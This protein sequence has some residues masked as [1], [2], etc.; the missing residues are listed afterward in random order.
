VLLD[1]RSVTWSCTG[2]VV[3]C[4]IRAYIALRSIKDRRWLATNTVKEKQENAP[5]EIKSYMKGMDNK[6]L[7]PG[8]FKLLVWDIKIRIL[9][10]NS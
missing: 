3:V 8:S 9:N 7:V 2:K 6:V 5:A 4:E 10:S 1:T